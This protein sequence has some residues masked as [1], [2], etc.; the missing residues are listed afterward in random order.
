V[1]IDRRG[2]GGDDIVVLD[3]ADDDCGGGMGGGDDD[4]DE[5][6][7]SF[8]SILGSGS[9]CIMDSFSVTPLHLHFLY[10][11]PLVMIAYDGPQAIQ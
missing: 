4:V 10:F 1:D 5:G 9:C 2:G 3:A 11:L 7:M 8:S 6:G